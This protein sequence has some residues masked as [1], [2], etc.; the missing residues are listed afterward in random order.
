MSSLTI[1]MDEARAGM[2]LAEDLTDGHGTVL[3]PSGAVLSDSMLASLRRRGVESCAIAA[4][5]A[6]DG[7]GEDPAQASARALERLQRLFR[8]SAETEATG[9]LLQLLATYRARS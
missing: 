6:G 8:H 3:L 1:A 9:Q 5:D 2:M 4:P 7:D